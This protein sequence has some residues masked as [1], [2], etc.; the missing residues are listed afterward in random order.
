M[1]NGVDCAVRVRVLEYDISERIRRGTQDFS[2][3]QP[4]KV[5]CVYPSILTASLTNGQ[6]YGDV[7]KCRVLTHRL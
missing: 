4:R 5:F 6:K 7:S 1:R 2:L 3:G